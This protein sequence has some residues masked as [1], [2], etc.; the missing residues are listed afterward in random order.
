MPI[1]FLGLWGGGC[2]FVFFFFGEGGGDL[3][4]WARGFS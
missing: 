1:K 2:I 4:L 3:I